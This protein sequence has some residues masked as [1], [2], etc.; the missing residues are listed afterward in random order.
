MDPFVHLSEDR[1]NEMMKDLMAEGLTKD[2]AFTEICAVD[3]QL[4]QEEE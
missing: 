3:C 2:E 1:V 4:D